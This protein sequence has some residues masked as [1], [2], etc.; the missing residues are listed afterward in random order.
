M[1]VK[2]IHFSIQRPSYL[3]DLK[4]FIFSLSYRISVRKI[5]ALPHKL[6]LNFE[7]VLFFVCFNKRSGIEFIIIKWLKIIEQKS[8]LLLWRIKRSGERS[9]EV[10]HHIK[11][12]DIQISIFSFRILKPSPHYT[13]SFPGYLTSLELLGIPF[14]NSRPTQSNIFPLPR[15]GPPPFI[16]EARCDW[17]LRYRETSLCIVYICAYVCMHVCVCVL[18]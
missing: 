16:L 5:V 6:S 12:S 17:F 14:L 11:W 13:V 1:S 2:S 10:R 9:G 8:C 15:T 4:S 18:S 3:W 7:I